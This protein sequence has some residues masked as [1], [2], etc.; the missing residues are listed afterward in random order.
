MPHVLTPG[1]KDERVETAAYLLRRFKRMGK[2]AMLKIVTGDETRVHYFEPRRKEQNKVWVPKGDHSL[3]VA[4]REQT[5][6]KV[7]YAIFFNGEGFIAQIFQHLK[8]QL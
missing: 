6:D 3:Q 8:V 4:K 1:Q 5:K 7:M 2:S